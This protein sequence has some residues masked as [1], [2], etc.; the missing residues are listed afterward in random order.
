MAS[1]TMLTL[2]TGYNLS[3]VFLLG[4]INYIYL[5]TTTLGILQIPYYSL[6]GVLACFLHIWI[7]IRCTSDNIMLMV[8]F[9][10][11]LV[12]ESSLCLVLLQDDGVIGI[13]LETALMP[14][15]IVGLLIN[16]V[17]LAIIYSLYKSLI[18]KK[19]QHWRSLGSTFIVLFAWLCISILL[20]RKHIEV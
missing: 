2:S 18:I 4:R 11:F 10:I 12:T 1:A 9:F 17:L 3:R 6:I 14:F 13:T 7:F 20:L 19:N 15:Q 16:D 8:V 5:V